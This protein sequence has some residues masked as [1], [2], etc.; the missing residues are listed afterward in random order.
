[1]ERVQVGDMLR[2]DATFAD[3]N[4]VPSDPTTVILKARW[5]SL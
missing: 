5:N 2:I 3:L 1:M 4:G